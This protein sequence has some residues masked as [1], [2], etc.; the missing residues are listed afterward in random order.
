MA[1]GAAIEDHNA[2]VYH[3]AMHEHYHNIREYHRAMREW[4]AD[5][6]ECNAGHRSYCDHPRPIY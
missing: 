1:T 3:R 6:A 5:V 2:M 4:R